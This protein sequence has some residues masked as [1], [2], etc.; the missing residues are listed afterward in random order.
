MIGRKLEIA[1]FVVIFFVCLFLTI[2]PIL[3][4]KAATLPINVGMSA[5][6]VIKEAHP[7]IEQKG[8]DYRYT[9]Q[10]DY[11]F[12]Y[13][14]TDNGISE[15][16][17]GYKNDVSGYILNLPGL[18]GGDI[19]DSRMGMITLGEDQALSILVKRYFDTDY[20]IM[21]T[22]LNK[23]DVTVYVDGVEMETISS[24]GGDVRW[25]HVITDLS[26]VNEI[27]AMYKGEKIHIASGQQIE[28]AFKE[29]SHAIIH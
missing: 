29:G 24:P 21:I 19:A 13:V 10:G 9:T 27:Y 1:V 28:K 15:F 2:P 4:I 3:R 23:P 17:V 7:D 20:I 6:E 14:M 11:L 8:Y 5:D 22:E 26:Q 25:V 12:V 16:N 18:V